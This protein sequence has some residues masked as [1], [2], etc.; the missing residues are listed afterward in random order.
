MNKTFRLVLLSVLL[1]FA[2]ACA[3]PTSAPGGAS[4]AG[5]QSS[6]ITCDL[7]DMTVTLDKGGITGMTCLGNSALL[8]VIV[9][10]VHPNGDLDRV[11]LPEEGSTCDQWN[12]PVQHCTYIKNGTLVSFTITR[13]GPDPVAAQTVQ[14]VVPTPYGGWSQVLQCGE[15]DRYPSA[16]GEFV[17][18]LFY[19]SPH[20]YDPSRLTTT[21]KVE[22]ISP[23]SQVLMADPNSIL[24]SLKLVVVTSSGVL[25][26]TDTL[27][28]T[29]A[30]RDIMNMSVDQVS[31][32]DLI[33]LPNVTI[34]GRSA[35]F[36]QCEKSIYDGRTAMVWP[37]ES[38]TVYFYCTFQF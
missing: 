17:E 22:C 3:L 11:H 27:Y 28:T 1:L 23:Q 35:L 29:G 8:V 24:P 15:Y 31:Q 32:V 36:L 18:I 14:A 30:F 6:E 38:M 4:G 26:Y 10:F 20:Y 9:D 12:V 33:L 16:P 37:S 25:E 5:P 7:G 13:H 21:L 2:L 19:Y 34:G